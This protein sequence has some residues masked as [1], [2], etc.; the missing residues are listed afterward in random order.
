MA[1]VA[2]KAKV[3]VPGVM[4]A[5]IYSIDTF[6]LISIFFVICHHVSAFKY[7]YEVF[8]PNTAITL[9]YYFFA[10]V[11]FLPFFFIAAG[12]FFRKGVLKGEPLMVRLRKYCARLARL[13]ILWSVFYAFFTGVPEKG[14]ANAFQIFYLNTMRLVNHPIDFLTTGTIENFWFFPALIMGLI[15]VA[16]LSRLGKEKYI[17]P[18]GVALYLIALLGKPYSVLPFGY[19]AEFDMTHGPFVSTLFVGV[20][21]LLADGKRKYRLRTA[22]WFVGAGIILQLAEIVYLYTQ[23]SVVPKHNYMLGTVLF[24]IG[25]FTCAL[26]RPDFGKHTV[27]PRWGYLTLGVYCIHSFFASYF[28]M[29][30]R[31][32]H[33][34]AFDILQPIVV[35][36]LSIWATLVLQRNR[37][38]RILV[39]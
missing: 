24:N 25:I 7:S 36:L 10:N 5:R 16:S 18:A 32:L 13:F 15:L 30:W 6:R 3:A 17:I 35:Y 1:I 4:S 9:L 28:G 38:T 29:L 23:Y 11:R 14:H 19:H 26:A 21:W 39:T 33:P 8:Y 27:F 2:D 12:Y 22:L 37:W 34:L 20:G 31:L